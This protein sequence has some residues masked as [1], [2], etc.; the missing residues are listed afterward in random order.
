MTQE[1]TKAFDGYEV[2]FI[3]GESGGIRFVAKE[4]AAILKHSNTSAMVSSYCRDLTERYTLSTLGGPQ[5][6]LTVSEAD[7]YRIVCGSRLPAARR[8]ER[9]VFE[10]VLPS[11]RK[12][13]RYD[14]PQSFEAMT[15]AVVTGLQKRLQD[16]TAALVEAKPKVEFYDTCANARGKYGLQ[17]AARVISQQPNKW[18]DSLKRD[19]FLFYQGGQLVPYAQHV[20]AELFEVK[21]TVV[22]DKTHQQTYVTPKGIQYFAKRI[23]NPQLLIA[24][25]EVYQ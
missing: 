2:R 21:I 12:T 19:G 20:Q 25:E 5:E 6:V 7:A 24:A 3:V 14:A 9:W 8:F 22:A 23:A 16:A 11:I 17:N 15:L 4:L 18:I 1:L 13:G 10:E